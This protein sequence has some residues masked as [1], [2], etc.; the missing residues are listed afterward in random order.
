[1]NCQEAI[2]RAD[3][4]KRNTVSA[5]LKCLWLKELDATVLNHVISKHEGE[6][7]SLPSYSI[8]SEED[9]LIPHP[10]DVIYP[11]YIVMRLDDMLQETEKY[12][13]SSQ[14]FNEALASYKACVSFDMPR[15]RT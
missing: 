3:E 9:L 12:N 6:I 5:E 8:E 15:S 7:P 2:A 14:L 11:R 1:M 10:Y 13:H 4:Y